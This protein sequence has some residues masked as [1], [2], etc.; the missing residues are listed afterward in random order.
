MA[1]WISH[2]DN[3]A[4]FLLLGNILFGNKRGVFIQKIILCNSK[5]SNIKLWRMEFF[6]YLQ[7]Q[8][9]MIIWLKEFGTA[10]KYRISTCKYEKRSPCHRVRRFIARLPVIRSQ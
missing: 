6:I 4:Y 10:E 1:L 9:Y 5:K 8:I 2:I 3:I 7:N